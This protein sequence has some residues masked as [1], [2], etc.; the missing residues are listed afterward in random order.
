MERIV[1]LRGV[2][3]FAKLAPVEVKQVAAIAGERVYEDGETLGRQ[4]D[5]GEEMYVIVAG[6]VRVMMTR[7]DGT[8]VEA[9][10]R[11]VGEYVGE[12][13]IL[14]QEPRI[15]TLI[16][17]GTVRVLTIDQRSFERILR[18]RPETGLAVIRELCARLAESEV[19]ATHVELTLA[20]PSM[21]VT[22]A[23]D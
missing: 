23:T 10:R 16:A 14:T 4:G 3:L 6:Q 15:A 8:S 5:P 17:A 20:T 9:V 12:M 1:F 13:A 11:T 22:S 21:A 19:R 7:A 18:E 2:P